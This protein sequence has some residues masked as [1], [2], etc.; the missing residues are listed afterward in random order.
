MLLTGA[1][2]L[3]IADFGFATTLDNLSQEGPLSIGSTLYMSPEALSSYK[4]S[5]KSDIWAIGV[6]FFE[7]LT[8]AVPW[9]EKNK[10]KMFAKIMARPVLTLLPKGLDVWIYEF[11]HRALDPNETSRASIQELLSLLPGEETDY[12]VFS[13]KESETEVT[14]DSDHNILNISECITSHAPSESY[15]SKGPL[16]SSSRSIVALTARMTDRITSALMSQ[17]DFFRLEHELVR[18]VGCMKSEIPSFATFVNSCGI[19][20]FIWSKIQQR[21]NRIEEV[22]HTG[23]QE[24]QADEAAAYKST[25]DHATILRVV[26]QYRVKYAPEM[27]KLPAKKLLEGQ[28]SE[29]LG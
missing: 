7:M 28:E 25:G 22:N 14:N 9:R 23:L 1:G 20:E 5:N 29:C 17:I 26:Q 4:Y 13:H 24:I 12:S 21:W 15:L 27:K 8:G 2:E 11:L 18:L 16:T 6:T 3:R 19:E 10:K